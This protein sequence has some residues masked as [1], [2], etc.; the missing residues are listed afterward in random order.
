MF[1]SVSILVVYTGNYYASRLFLPSK[2]YYS[3]LSYSEKEK[4]QENNAMVQ[5]LVLSFCGGFDSGSLPQ[6]LKVRGIVEKKITT[7]KC[8]RKKRRMNCKVCRALF[9][10]FPLHI[11]K[12]LNCPTECIEE[13]HM[14]CVPLEDRLN[15]MKKRKDWSDFVLK[16]CYE[17][18]KFL[19]DI[20]DRIS[21]KDYF[22]VSEKE[23]E[24][25]KKRKIVECD[26]YTIHED[27]RETIEW[28]IALGIRPELL[29]SADIVAF[30]HSVTGKIRAKN[31]YKFLMGKETF[32]WMLSKG[33]QLERN[34][35]LPLRKD[36][37]HVLEDL[38][39]L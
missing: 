10:S 17:V 29:S 32:D 25:V 2:Q 19:R 34:I 30:A 26:V 4:H 12:R 39:Q 33:F 21:F 7:Y 27:D 15:I 3:T 18:W 14:Y 16:P 31:G 6:D 35:I 23:A 37:Y 1:I 38:P 36:E 9:K 20:G 24:T 22:G 5:S 28:F 8:N 13:K 11:I